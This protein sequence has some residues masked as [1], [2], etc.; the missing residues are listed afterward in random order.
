MFW[1]VHFGDGTAGVEKHER[2]AVCRSALRGAQSGELAYLRYETFAVAHSLDLTYAAYG[3]ELCQCRRFTL[4]HVEQCRVGKDDIR[5]HFCIRATSARTALSCSKSCCTGS[6]E[7]SLP[8]A[9]FC[10]PHLGGACVER[11]DKFFLRH[12]T[13]A[14]PLAWAEVIGI[15]ISDFHRSELHHLRYIIEPFFLRQVA[16]ASK[17]GSRS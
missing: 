14:C 8:L 6:D 15:L 10:L 2:L 13:H 4:R 1:S 16:A 12:A 17:V 7:T 11:E 5:R 3:K 9:F